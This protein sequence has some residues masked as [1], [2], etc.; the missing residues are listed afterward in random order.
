MKLLIANKLGLKGLDILRAQKQI[1]F[2]YFESISD[3]K[4]LKII[5][6]YDAVIV[7]SKPQISKTVIQAGKNL[8]LIARAGVGLDNIDLKTAAKHNIEVINAPD[9]NTISAAEHTFA[10]MLATARHLIPANESL[11]AGRWDRKLFLGTELFGKTLALIGCGRI[12]QHVNQIAQGFQMKVIGYDPFVDETQM[13][14]QQI[15]KIETLNKTLQEADI[16]SLHLPHIPETH[17]LIGKKELKQMKSHAI[18]INCARGGIIDE[19][20]LFTALQNKTIQAA[21]IDVWENEPDTKNPL[22]KLPNVV[23]IPHLGASTH[24]AQVRVSEIIIQKTLQKLLK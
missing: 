24:E 19:K 16:V 20:T 15:Q 17:H 14:A 10:L 13:A 22:Q 3:K 11:K 8:K 1:K 23:A 7:R 12:A 6:E 18:L 9:A 2:D 4:L 21:G 5:P